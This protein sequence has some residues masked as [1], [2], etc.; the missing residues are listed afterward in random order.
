M[1]LGTSRFTVRER[2]KETE[3]LYHVHVSSF[4]CG[5]FNEKATVPVVQI[6]YQEP[7]EDPRLFC[8]L[9]IGRSEST[10]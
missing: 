2:E 4:R 7:E 3:L 9:W 10:S 8:Y 5:L 1:A 6:A